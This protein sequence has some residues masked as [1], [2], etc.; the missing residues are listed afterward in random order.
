MSEI[1]QLS[2]FELSGLVRAGDISPRESVEA[3]LARIDEVNPELNAFVHVCAERARDEAR[4]Q[5][6]A[7]AAGESIGPLAGVPLG[8]KDLEDVEG[9]P[10]SFGSLAWRNYVAPRDSVQVSRLRAAGAIVVGKTN[11]PEFGY[12]GFTKNRVFGISRNPWNAERTPGGSSGG[13]AA[14]IAAR[15]V[16]LATASDG[17]GSVRIPACFVGAFGLKP[18]FGRIPLGPEPHHMLRW[19][20]TV[21]QGPLTRSVRDAAL[22]LDVAAG[23]HPADPNSLPAP[24]GSYLDCLQQPLPRHT[25]IA[26]SP[27]LGYARVDP[28]VRREVLAAVDV[29]ARLGHE[30]EQIST[31]FPDVGRGWAYASGAEVYAELAREVAGKEH[32]LGKGFWSGTVAASHLSVVET[33]DIQRERFALNEVLARLFD[34]YDL[35]LT[36]TLPTAAFAAEGPLPSIVDGQPLESPLHAVAFTYPFNFSGHPAASVRAGF[37]DNGLPV[38]LQIVAERHRD[39]LVLRAAAAYD[40]ERP[41]DRWPDL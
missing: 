38:G 20:D 26:F 29:F 15:M 2:S 25:R 40:N 17:G 34:R 19:V 4:V 27:D 41:M 16:P 36:P 14:A 30:V 24:S 18:S 5:E 33:G 28:Q 6:R 13:S 8:V 35:L 39:D 37:T 9:L 11:T 32:E 3:A 7:L 31:V 1:W 10:T 22:F 23:Y 21:H 12:T